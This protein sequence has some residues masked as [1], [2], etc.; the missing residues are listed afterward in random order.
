MAACRL[1]NKQQA[2]IISL[3]PYDT[4][5]AA[6]ET[7]TASVVILNKMPYPKLIASDGHTSAQVPHSVHMSGLIEYFS[8]SEIA[9]AGHSSIQVPQAIQLSPIT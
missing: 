8:P 3:T 9:P 7:R 2:A 5:K 4:K 1:D 6:R